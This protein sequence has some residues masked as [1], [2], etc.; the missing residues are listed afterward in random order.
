VYDVQPLLGNMI[1]SYLYFAASSFW[2]GS[3]RRWKLEREW[4]D[5][6]V[7]GP[8]QESFRQYFLNEAPF[9]Q[10]ARVY[11][12]VAQEAQPTR[13]VVPPCTSR[14]DNAHR[15]E[16]YIPG[17]H[18]V[19]VLGQGAPQYYDDAALNGS[20]GHLMCLCPWEDSALFRGMATLIKTSTS[21]GNLR[22]WDGGKA[23]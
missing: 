3:A 9:P 2:R 21:V 8:Y 5:C 18:F 1:E 15:H 6:V 13:A 22:Q 11:V 17:I 10:Y 20:R 4:L 16:F 14:I 23:R 7:L 19:L 12:F